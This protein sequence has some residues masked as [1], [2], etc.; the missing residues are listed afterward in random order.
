MTDL[1]RIHNINYL[2]CTKYHS[3]LYL[4]PST[5]YIHKQSSRKGT[6]LFKAIPPQLHLPPP[7]TKPK[8]NKQEPFNQ[9]FS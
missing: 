3:N 7:K 2:Y 8:A 9:T 4:L 1:D 6:L 5:L